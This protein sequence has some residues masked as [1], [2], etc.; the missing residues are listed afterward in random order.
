VSVG[1]FLAGKGTR[2]ALRAGLC[3]AQVGEFSFIIAGLG[4]ASGATRPDFYPLAVGIS[5]LTAF[6]SPILIAH[7]DPLAALVERSLPARITTFARLYAGWLASI[8]S[9]G[10]RSSR[11]GVVRGTALVVLLDALVLST[12]LIGGALAQQQLGALLEG[13]T[14]LAPILGELSVI[15]IVTL[16]CILPLLGMV[17]GARRLGAQLAGMAL[18]PAFPGQLDDNDTARRALTAGLQLAVLLAVALPALLVTEPFLPGFTALGLLL[19]LLVMAYSM[20]WRS[21]TELQGQVRAGAQVIVETIGNLGRRELPPVDEFAAL[22]PSLGPVVRVAV[23]SGHGV[24]GATLAELGL[25]SVADLTVLSIVRGQRRYV[26]PHGNEIV[27]AGD[28]LSI[29]GKSG[30][31]ALALEALGLQPSAAEAGG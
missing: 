2:S 19:V 25:Y 30:K 11:W 13:Q 27:C 16:L 28:E 14:T 1:A 20:I 26:L 5:T 9:Q 21:T 23:P 3:M 29:A 4:V 18:P 6:V 8:R 22:L 10:S 12:L 31:L 17:R 15:V 24:V 7:A